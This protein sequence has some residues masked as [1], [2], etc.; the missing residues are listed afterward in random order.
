MAL[1]LLKESMRLGAIYLIIEGEVLSK[2]FCVISMVEKDEL[3][4]ATVIITDICVHM[5]FLCR[6]RHLLN[7]RV[8]LAVRILHRVATYL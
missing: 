2:A 1:D 6:Y 5:C 7:Y 4:I 8:F 3:F